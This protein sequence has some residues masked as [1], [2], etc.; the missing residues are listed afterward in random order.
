MKEADI[1]GS[2]SSAINE[3]MDY[4]E[5]IGYVLNLK[6]NSGYA[7]FTYAT[8]SIKE[9]LTTAGKILEVYTYHKAKALGKFDD[10]VSSYE[11]DWQD[12]SVKNELD[13]IVTH[14]FCSLFVECKA[15][16]NIEQDFYFKLL[17]LKDR[18]GINATAV[19]VADT[20][21]EQNKL[22]APVNS[23]Q[24]SR[25]DMMDVV[26][27]WKPEEIKDIGNVLFRIINGT[28]KNNEEA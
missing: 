22:I 13:L 8:R 18:F 9:L 24:R 4:F 14:K 7:S 10:V 23:M 19:L 2:D 27:I 28:Y 11:I 1:G 20:Q 17:E 15:R 3:L 6:R 25:G 21:E 12:T 26:T 16:L 5:R